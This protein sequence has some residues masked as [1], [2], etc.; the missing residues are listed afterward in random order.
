MAKAM[1]QQADIQ[2]L[3]AMARA[4]IVGNSVK[5]E[6]SI[7]NKT[8][9]ITNENVLNIA[10]RYAGLVLGFIVEI[11]ANL[12]NSGGSTANRT[13]F[14]TANLVQQVRFDDLS[15]YTRVQVPGWYLALLNT[16]RQ[17]FGFGGSYA[18]AIPMNYGDNFG[19]YAGPATIAAAGNANVRQVYYVPL[20]YSNTDL[21]GAIY[22]S[23]VNATMNLQITLNQAPGFVAGNPLNAIY[24]GAGTNVAYGNGG[25]VTVNVYQVY[26]D[27]L[28]RTEQG[29]VIL[30]P[31]DLNM[32]YDLKQTTYSGVTAGQDF[33][34]AY[35]NFRQF[36][37]TVAVYDNAGVF[38]AGTD[39]NYWALQAANFANIFKVSPKYSALKTR[40][41]IMSDLP[42]GTY[43]FSSRDIPINT[44]NY[45]N[46]ELVINPVTAGAGARV[47]VGYESFG[48]VNQLAGASSLGPL[49]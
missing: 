29:S 47:L 20:A 15:N 40:S 19:V 36:L 13:Q 25:N 24:G 32:I 8:V 2:T 10:P 1:Q 18:N 16:I 3:N 22:A 27:Q 14:G 44:I 48:L 38:N 37:S 9:N 23:I 17:G 5:M 4:A 35:S 46:M 33:P 42:L 43:L 49:G 41:A 7:F 6:Q 11:E 34:M 26:L 28:P 30:P 39:I 21:R 31:L 45:G 12:A